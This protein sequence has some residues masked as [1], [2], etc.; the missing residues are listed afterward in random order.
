MSHRGIP[1]IHHNSMH[2]MFAA[3]SRGEEMFLVFMTNAS[4]L[5]CI[6]H[7]DG[8]QLALSLPVSCK[9]VPIATVTS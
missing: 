7:G 6:L 9:A 1:Y 2:D 3:Y 5:A 4:N 8:K